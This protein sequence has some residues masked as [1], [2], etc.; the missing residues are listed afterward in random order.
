MTTST[1]LLRR[2]RFLPLFATQLLGAFNDNLY[3]NA[4]V[5]F[6]VYGVFNSE[7]SEA[8][9]SAVAS[10]LFIVPFFV[11]SAL[12]GQ[13]ADMRDK[14]QII[15]WVK[16]AEIL[17]MLAGGAGLVI[18]WQAKHGIL[19]PWENILLM[20]VAMPLILLALLGMGI[21]STFSARSNMRSC[22]NI[23]N[24]R[25]CWPVRALSRQ[26]P[27]LPFWQARFWPVSSRWNGRQAGCWRPR[28]SA[29]P[30]AC[31]CP[32]RRRRKRPSRWISISCAPRCNW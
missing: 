30:L 16:L 19:A 31:R 17:I 1:H 32:L 29:M 14:A 10:A 9:F 20:P 4:A 23:S 6:V 22:L 28:L 15:R 11:L 8:I 7:K 13:L 21:H 5:F 24:L 27:I 25:K 2:R 18:A 12:A 26:A 3:K